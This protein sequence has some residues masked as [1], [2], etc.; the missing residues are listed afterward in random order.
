MGSFF[1]L[2]SDPTD[3]L[4]FFTM[5]I[6]LLITSFV[7]CTRKKRE[8][9]TSQLPVAQ[10][11]AA[12]PTFRFS[13]II[14]EVEATTLVPRPASETYVEPNFNSTDC[15]PKSASPI[16]GLA[17]LSSKTQGLDAVTASVQPVNQ[18]NKKKNNES[19]ASDEGCSN[20]VK[21]TETK[22][23][24][25]SKSVIVADKQSKRKEAK[26]TNHKTTAVKSMTKNGNCID[27]PNNLVDVTLS[28][29]TNLKTGTI[30]KPEIQV[31]SEKPLDKTVVMI[32][33]TQRQKLQLKTTIETQ[34]PSQAN[35]NNISTEKQ[36]KK[37]VKI[38][39]S[40]EQCRI[41]KTELVE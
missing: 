2:L 36:S 16:T 20:P 3:L 19:K 8:L 13:N 32:Q 21:A 26:L 33:E 18:E 28:Q 7:L 11:P 41:E 9:K 4:V 39:K 29:F 17:P 6:F 14:S 38:Q 30:K 40:S 1:V 25:A 22:C 24:A 34:E 23:A 35:E 27:I 5:P 10:P 15:T 31:S 37:A 12:N